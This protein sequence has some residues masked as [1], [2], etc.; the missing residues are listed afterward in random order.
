L[1]KYFNGVLTMLVVLIFASFD[2]SAFTLR[3]F[4]CFRS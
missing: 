1:S 4:D 2:S 3:K